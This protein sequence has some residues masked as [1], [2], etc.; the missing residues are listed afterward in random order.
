MNKNK[1]MV[2]TFFFL[3]LSV[4]P[5]LSKANTAIA[6]TQNFQ[7]FQDFQSCYEDKSVCINIVPTKPFHSSEDSSFT[8]EV[9]NPQN[10]VVE[11]KNFSLFMLMNGDGPNH[12]APPVKW[13]KTSDKPLKFFITEADFYMQGVWLVQVEFKDSRFL[14][15]VKISVPV[16]VAQ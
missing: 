8:A 12:P 4:V 16:K 2:G 1:S 6:P 9:I 5:I 14:E 11:V 10:T 15:L 7:N 13:V 3:F